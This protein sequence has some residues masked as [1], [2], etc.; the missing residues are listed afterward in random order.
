MI[1][2]DR[3]YIDSVITLI[4]SASNFYSTKPSRHA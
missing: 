1:F 4:H 2:P 3:T